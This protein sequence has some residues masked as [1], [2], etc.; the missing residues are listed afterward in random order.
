LPNARANGAFSNIKEGLVFPFNLPA[1]IKLGTA[2]SFNFKL[3]A[4]VG[5][6]P[7]KTDRCA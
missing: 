1:I 7:R 2:T 4:Q 6:R 5:L 3:I